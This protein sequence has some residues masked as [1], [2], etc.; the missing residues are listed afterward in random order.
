[1]RP[2]I[3][4]DMALSFLGSIL[5]SCERSMKYGTAKCTTT[6]ST[7]TTSQPFFHRP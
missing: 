7:D 6:M 3:Q 2:R 1:M 5:E 4:Y